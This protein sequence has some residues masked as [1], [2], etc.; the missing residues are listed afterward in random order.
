MP[1]KAKGV[2]CKYCSTTL[3]NAITAVNGEMSLRQAEAIFKVSK[4]TI[5]DHVSG[6]V[7]ERRATGTQSVSV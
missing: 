3:K 6:R 4:S 7:A 5:L 2:R 1:R